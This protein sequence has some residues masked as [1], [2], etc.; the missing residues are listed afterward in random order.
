MGPGGGLERVLEPVDLEWQGFF[1]QGPKLGE[2]SI[3]DALG[4][5]PFG[6]LEHEVVFAGAV[7]HPGKADSLHGRLPWFEFRNGY[8]QLCRRQLGVPPV[9]RKARI[10]ARVAS[11]AS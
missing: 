10:A 9:S 8:R 4:M 5:L 2:D 7:L 3:D 11:G 1:L 6:V